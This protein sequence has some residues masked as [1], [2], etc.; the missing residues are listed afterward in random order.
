MESRKEQ[1]DE[2]PEDFQSGSYP[3]EDAATVAL[4]RLGPGLAALAGIT[5]RPL[6]TD[7]TAKSQSS[8]PAAKVMTTVFTSSVSYLPRWWMTRL[9]KQRAGWRL[10]L[11]QTWQQSWRS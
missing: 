7:A 8:I 9:L 5:N 1:L 3:V 2:L 6:A 4:R 11:P 10:E